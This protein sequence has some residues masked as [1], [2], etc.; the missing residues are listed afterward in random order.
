MEGSQQGRLVDLPRRIG[1]E[2]VGAAEVE[3]D[4]AADDGH[5]MSGACALTLLTKST[6]YCSP[7]S[8]V[9]VEV[10]VDGIATWKAEGEQDHVA[11]VI[12]ASKGAQELVSA[13]IAHFTTR[14][15]T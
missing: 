2:R 5:P 1:A 9:T 6:F 15:L 11:T 12:A 3:G 10:D 13:S 8:K 7:S 4:C 14:W